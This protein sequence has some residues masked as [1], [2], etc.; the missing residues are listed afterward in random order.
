MKTAYFV[1]T[2]VVVAIIILAVSNRKN[3][4]RFL[5]K[6]ETV[7]AIKQFILAAEKYIVGDKK[8]QERL[9]LVVE[10]L[11]DYLPDWAK[12]VVT[13]Q[14]LIEAVNYV[15]EQLAEKIDGHTIAVEKAVK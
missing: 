5:K 7:N 2:G 15:F 1:I 14:M 9:E 12:K 6:P 10:R 3:I 11:M 8:G 4:H 13:R